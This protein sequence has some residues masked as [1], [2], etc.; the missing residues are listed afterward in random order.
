M[1]NQQ[2]FHCFHRIRLD[3]IITSYAWQRGASWP[4]PGLVVTSP[5]VSFKA[6]REHISGVSSTVF[7]FLHSACGFPTS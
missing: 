6:R 3:L 5:T 1:Q 7:T 2:Q 4:H